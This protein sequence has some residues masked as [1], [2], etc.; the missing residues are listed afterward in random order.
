MLRRNG[1]LTAKGLV[2]L[3]QEDRFRLQTDDGR[4]ILL[5]LKPGTNVSMEDIESLANAGETVIAEYEGEPEAGA[6]ALKVRR[7]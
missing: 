5:T 7:A 4:S 3:A 2:V 6:V 1:R